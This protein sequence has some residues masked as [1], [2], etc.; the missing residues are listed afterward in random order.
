MECCG[1]DRTTPYCPMCGKIMNI[2]PINELL[3][4]VKKYRDALEVD[5]AE[6]I[7]MHGEDGK[8]IHKNSDNKFREG[9][10]RRL[11]K[12]DGW[13]KALTALLEKKDTE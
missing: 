8:K 6:T 1:Y 9:I 11:K 5:L 7:E 4:H 12:W 10:E 2:C 13:Y 3:H